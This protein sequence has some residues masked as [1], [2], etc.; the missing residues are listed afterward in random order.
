MYLEAYEGIAHL[1]ASKDSFSKQEGGNI[2]HALGHITKSSRLLSGLNSDNDVIKDKIQ[3]YL[4]DSEQYRTELND[5]NNNVYNEKITP[6]DQLPAIEAKNFAVLRSMESELTKFQDKSDEKG[7]SSSPKLPI[8]P[9][10][11]E[12]AKVPMNLTPTPEVNEIERESFKTNT[13]E[14]SEISVYPES[15]E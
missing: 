12:E 15:R 9:T 10:V 4:D 5:I 1:Y 8:V 3:E 13:S 2:S 6:E 11:P 14:E 7:G